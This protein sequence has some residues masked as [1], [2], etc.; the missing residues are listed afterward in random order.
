VAAH[1]SIG[2]RTKWKWASWSV[3]NLNST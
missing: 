1:I 3:T 2:D